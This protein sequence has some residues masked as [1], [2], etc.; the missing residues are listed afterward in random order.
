MVGAYHATYTDRFHE[1][2]RMVAKTEPTTIQ[3]AILKASVLTDE[4]IRNGALKRNIEKRGNSGE[5]SRDGNVRDDNKRSRNGRAFA[6][7]TNPVRKEYTCMAP[8]CLHCNF[9]HQ[10]EMPCRSC[11]NCNRLRHFAKDCR[12]GTRMV[13]PLNVRNLIPAHGACFKCGGTDHYKSA[14]PRL[15]RAQRPGGNHPEQAM[16]IKRG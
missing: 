13:N 9:H 3:S 5:P 10:P 8:K 14:C 16:A 6:T 1:L 15:N 12:V 2:A 7:N 4:A 11:T